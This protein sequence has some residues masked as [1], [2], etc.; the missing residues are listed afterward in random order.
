MITVYVA[1]DAF[2]VPALCELWV[3]KEAW[4]YD[5]KMLWKNLNELF[6]QYNICGF[7]LTTKVELSSYHRLYGTESVNYLLIR[8][9]REKVY[10]P[11]IYSVGDT[12]LK[13]LNNH[14]VYLIWFYSFI[15]LSPYRPYYLFIVHISIHIE[16]R[17]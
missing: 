13:K 11:V 17:C 7:F 1:K 8:P 9:L 6:G 3:K 15:L 12:T 5:R 4:I 14:F 2:Y 16:I 10:Q